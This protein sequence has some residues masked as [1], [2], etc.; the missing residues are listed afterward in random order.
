MSFEEVKRVFLENRK[1]VLFLSSLI[2]FACLALIMV[3]F[4]Q[5]SRIAY[6]VFPSS[7]M[8]STTPTPTPVV[9][10][11]Y[12][13][14]TLEKSNEFHMYLIGD[15]M[16][17]AL[18]PRGGIFNEEVSNA[19]KGM[20]LQIFNYSE[21]NQS[22]QTLPQRLQEPV[23]ADHDLLLPPVLEGEPDLI[24]IESFGYNPLSDYGVEEGLK[25]QNE[26]PT[27]ETTLRMHRSTTSPL[28]MFLRSH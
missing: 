4:S 24:I 21:A 22:I 2:F 5:P 18:G 28:S 23:Q 10:T 1:Q 19:H 13:K 25:R 6:M 9:F 26:F 14:P 17:H 16:T 20:F 8:T 27:L 11:L 15:S 12:T 7:T 3:V